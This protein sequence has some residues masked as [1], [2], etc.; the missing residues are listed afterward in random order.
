M[1]SLVRSNR[2]QHVRILGVRVLFANL[3]RR[4]SMSA[5]IGYMSPY[6]L[7]EVEAE[8]QKTDTDFPNCT[9]TEKMN[10]HTTWALSFST[11]AMS[12]YFSRRGPE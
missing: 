2:G 5:L 4:G 12:S 7:Q 10:T 6:K 9:A 1:C 3:M 8:C 11:P